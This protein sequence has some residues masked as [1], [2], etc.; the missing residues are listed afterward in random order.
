VALIDDPNL[1]LPP[2][3]RQVV[4]ETEV[5]SASGAAVPR[6]RVV[7]SLPEFWAQPSVWRHFTKG[8]GAASGF[9]RDLQPRD[10]AGRPASDR[11][12]YPLD[13][14]I[15]KTL[16]PEGLPTQPGIGAITL[17]ANART[18]FIQWNGV[19]G[20]TYSLQFTPTLLRPFAATGPV[21]AQTP[22][23]QTVSLPLPGEAG[24]YRVVELTP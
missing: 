1:V 13:R 20:H 19:V 3:R 16:L 11:R 23:V 10:W 6:L 2:E 4:L 9:G 17:T 5:E 21:I 8:V 18:V 22:G 24:F 14:G 12:A 15:A 7:D